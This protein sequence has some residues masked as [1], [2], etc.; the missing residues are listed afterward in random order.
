MLPTTSQ[1]LQQQQQ[2]QHQQQQQQQNSQQGQAQPS[3]VT[4]VQQ[5]QPVYIDK[6]F[7]TIQTFDSSKLFF[8]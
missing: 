4:I 3:Q 2:Q 7:V 8:V 6:F 1:Q 5:H